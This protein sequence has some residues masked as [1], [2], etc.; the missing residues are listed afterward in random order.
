MRFDMQNKDK[1]GIIPLST[2]KKG[3]RQIGILFERGQTDTALLLFRRTVHLLSLLMKDMHFS[4]DLLKTFHH[5]F[6]KLDAISLTGP[7]PTAPIE[8]DEFA[9]LFER[10]WSYIEL[11][12]KKTNPLRD[13]LKITPVLKVIR[14]Y[15]WPLMA[16][17]FIL[18]SL[19]G[20][21]RLNENVLL[22]NHGLIGEYYLDMNFNKLA[23]KRRDLRINFHWGEKGPTQ[24]LRDH[25]DY[26]SIRWT[27]FLE[28]P[29]SGNHIF[30]TKSDDGV[31]LWINNTLIIDDWVSHPTTLN[32]GTVFLEKGRVPVKLEYFEFNRLAELKLMWKQ[33]TDS[34]SK[35]IDAKYF[36]PE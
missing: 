17:V 32:T 21:K 28:I 5:D 9:F 14:H 30:S 36:F 23:L 22:K 12:E 29:S 25:R 31:R 24:T 6:K 13:G 20:I 33:E 8:T 11:V 19:Y 4:S 2:L 27:G 35:I 10:L 26:F 7:Y 1:N 16:L 34:K 15:K 3:Y 18:V